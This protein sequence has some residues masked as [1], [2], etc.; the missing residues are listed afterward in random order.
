MGEGKEEPLTF[1][2][3]SVIPAEALV[4]LDRLSKEFIL[5]LD[6]QDGD[7]ALVDNHRVMH[8]RYPFAGLRKRSVVVC[9]ARD[10]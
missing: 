4:E 5:P 9:L 6:W 8:G 1:G 7:V 3:D 2:N 10:T